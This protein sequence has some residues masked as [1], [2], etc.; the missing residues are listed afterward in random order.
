VAG[1]LLAI[2][3]C[4]AREAAKPS[5][6]GVAQVLSGGQPAREGPVAT[7]VGLVLTNGDVRV[8]ATGTAA[9]RAG[10]LFE[11][12]AGGG[13]HNA[14]DEWYG[15]WTFLD[16]SVATPPTRVEV[17][18]ARGSMVAVRWTFG[19]H[20]TG[21]TGT[22][23]SHPYPFTKTVWLR[24]GNSGYFALLEP[25]VPAPPVE[26]RYTPG[27]SE[28]EIGFGGFYGPGTYAT[29]EGRHRAPGGRRF[30]AERRPVEAVE[31]QRDGDPLIRVLV[32]IPGG[33]LLVPDFGGGRS[34]GVFVHHDR[35]R[36]YGAYLHAAPHVNAQ[37]ARHVCREAWRHVPFEVPRVE[38]AAFERCGP[39]P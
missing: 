6:D 34:G 25:M 14:T 2:G 5:S 21:P 12:R 36:R 30:N 32:P 20:V 26:R 23:P 29:S 33:P 8:S 3:G 11:V 16:R 4:Q 22:E 24:Q 38:P 31:F 37:P 27:L 1:L 7:D 39:P 35:P 17:L 19:R 10:L 9:E 28:H 18:A 15:D 13:W